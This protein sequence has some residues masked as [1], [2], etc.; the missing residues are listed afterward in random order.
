MISRDYLQEFPDE[1]V[2]DVEEMLDRIE[3]EFIA[4]KA[5]QNIFIIHQIKEKFNELRFYYDLDVEWDEYN[6]ATKNLWE[7]RDNIEEIVSWTE[8]KIKDKFGKKTMDESHWE[9][10]KRLIGKDNKK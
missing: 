7:L 9:E 10:L 4:L 5:P 8:H 2:P 6:E 1:W 3:K